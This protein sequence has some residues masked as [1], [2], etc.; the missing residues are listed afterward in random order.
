MT[1]FEQFIK[2]YK[3]IIS[4]IE[5]KAAKE[6]GNYLLEGMKKYIPSVKEIAWTQFIP[7][8]NDGEV[9]E[10]EIHSLAFFSPE[11]AK[12][13]QDGE[14]I[15]ELTIENHYNYEDYVYQGTSLK[16]EIDAFMDNVWNKIPLVF[17]QKA[18]GD[19]AFVRISDSKIYVDEYGDHD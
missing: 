18:F 16:S 1:D 3:K 9:C 8:F 15:D 13:V 17:F 12:K 19:H 14:E 6:L 7:Y 2:N 10:F 5:A 11:F 4:E